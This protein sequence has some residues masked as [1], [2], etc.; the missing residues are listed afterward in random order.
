MPTIEELEEYF[1]SVE[2]PE[3]VVFNRGV[4]WRN[5]PGH[6]AQYIALIKQKGLGLYTTQPSFDRL[7]ELHA[8]LSAK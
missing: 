5:V 3:T 7:L 4:T 1:N 2:L 6:V 8:I